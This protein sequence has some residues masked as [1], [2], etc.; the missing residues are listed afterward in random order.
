MKLNALY[1]GSLH[2]VCTTQRHIQHIPTHTH[3]PT[4][5]P[6]NN[7]SHIQHINHTSHI[8]HTSTHIENTQITYIHQHTFTHPNTHAVNIQ[9]SH[10][11]TRPFRESLSRVLPITLVLAPG[12]FWCWWGWRVDAGSTAGGRCIVTSWGLCARLPT[13]LRFWYTAP[14]HPEAHVPQSSRRS[15]QQQ[16]FASSKCEQRRRVPGPCPQVENAAPVSLLTQ[17]ELSLLSSNTDPF[18]AALDTVSSWH[19]MSPPNTLL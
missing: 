8:Q 11:H 1:F 17:E 16:L 13:A 14:H 2:F 4:H 6:H 7:T 15:K 12:P 3:T 19:Q 18:T 9:H 5:L 10:T